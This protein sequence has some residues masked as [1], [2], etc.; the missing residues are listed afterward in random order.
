MQSRVPTARA[1]IE[2]ICYQFYYCKQGTARVHLKLFKRRAWYTLR[3]RAFWHDV[4]WL[5]HRD[6]GIDRS[7]ECM[8]FK[9]LKHGPFYFYFADEPVLAFRCPE[10]RGSV[11]VEGVK[12]SW[13]ALA[14]SL[15]LLGSGSVGLKWNKSLE[16]WSRRNLSRGDR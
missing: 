3:L 2:W 5:I 12:P 13:L 9:G 14:G 8:S 6:R 15:R 7:L 1:R 10:S 16:F 11:D 4:I